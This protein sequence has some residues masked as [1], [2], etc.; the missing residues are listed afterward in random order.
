MKARI[1][2]WCREISIR[3]ASCTDPI[4]FIELRTLW[5]KLQRQALDL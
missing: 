5:L 3:L 1:Q 2:A 4:K